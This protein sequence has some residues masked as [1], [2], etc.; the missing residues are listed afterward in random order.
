MLAYIDS[1][2][3]LVPCKA[4]RA[5]TD[6]HGVTYVDVIVTARNSAT[7]ARGDMLTF[8]ARSIVPRECVTRRRAMSGARVMPY[9]WRAI[10]PYL[11][12]D[13]QYEGRG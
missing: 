5:E 12:S 11:W 7:Y 4:L 9:D 2:A 8:T 1:F 3:G 13:A 10:A 6:S